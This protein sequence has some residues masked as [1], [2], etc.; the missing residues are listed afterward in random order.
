MPL[1]QGLPRRVVALAPLSEKV[2]V[3]GHAAEVYIEPRADSMPAFR[4]V[5]ESSLPKTGQEGLAETHLAGQSNRASG[6]EAEAG[7]SRS[8]GLDCLLYTS[9]AADE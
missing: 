7:A 9:D 2:E 6:S 4:V 5:S 1:E 8:Q 3:V